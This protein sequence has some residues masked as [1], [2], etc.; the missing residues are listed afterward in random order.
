MDRKLNFKSAK[1]RLGRSYFLTGKNPKVNSEELEPTYKAKAGE[2]LDHISYKMYGTPK[3]WW[4][5][6]KANGLANGTFAL[7]HPCILKIPPLSL[8]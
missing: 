4:I 5:I 2:R 3:Y 1:N 8:F 7:N 6:A